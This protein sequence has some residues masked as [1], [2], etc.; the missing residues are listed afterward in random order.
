MLDNRH[1]P[2][3]PPSRAGDSAFP[4]RDRIGHSLPVPGTNRCMRLSMLL[5]TALAGS[6]PNRTRSNS[7]RVSRFVL[8]ERASV[9]SLLGLICLPSESQLR[10]RLPSCH[11]PGWQV[12]ANLPTSARARNRDVLPHSTPTKRKP[13]RDTSC[14]IIHH[15]STRQYG[16]GI[17]EDGGS[18]Q[19]LSPSSAPFSPPRIASS[20][21][22]SVGTDNIVFS[23]STSI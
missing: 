11:P 2:A 5:T 20:G 19:A 6:H 1:G 10:R 7:N 23:D 9:K 16:C 8:L 18:G 22:C 13:L 4:G 3:D 17:S 12:Q 21:Q 14:V 15:I